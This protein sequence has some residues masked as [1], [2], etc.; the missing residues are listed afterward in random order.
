MRTDKC[1]CGLEIPNFGEIRRADSEMQS[2]QHQLTE[3]QLLGAC[4]CLFVCLLW[5]ECCGL[6]NIHGGGGQSSS[7]GAVKFNT[8]EV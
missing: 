7:C 6:G 3:Q 1:Q 5:S 4:V 8:D 2:Q